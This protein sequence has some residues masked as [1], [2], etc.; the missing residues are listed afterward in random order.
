MELLQNIS[1]SEPNLE[2]LQA[3]DMVDLNVSIPVSIA[4]PLPL[5]YVL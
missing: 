4:A 2:N 3:G 1:V 5:C